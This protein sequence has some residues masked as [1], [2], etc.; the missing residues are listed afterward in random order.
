M[1]TSDIS[2]VLVIGA[3]ASGAALSWRLG[4]AG[5]KVTC[6]EQGD[7]FPLDSYPMLQADWELRRLTDF[8]A[9]PNVRRRP[10]D[11]P[12][13]NSESPFAPLMFNGVGGST[14]HW[15]AHFPRF[16]PSDFRV[17][18]LDGVADDW[19]LTYEELEPYYDL[20]DR[21]IGVSGL[22]G[23]TAYPE[24]S[25]R[26]TPPLPIGSF[27]TTLARGFDR[28]GWHWWAADT[29]IISSPFGEGRLPCNNCGPCDVGC[30]RGSRSS[31]DVTYWPRAL[32]DGVHLVTNARVREITVGSDGLASGAL[33]YD[34]SGDVREAKAAVVVMAANGIGTPRL[35][36]NSTSAQFPD[37]LAN[38]NGLVGKNLMFHP[39]AAVAG[40]FD[41]PLDSFYGPIG[42]SVYSH[43]FYETD[44]RRGFLRGYQL[45][46]VRQAGPVSV[47]LGGFTGQRVPWGPDHHR[48]MAQRV[49]HIINLGIVG[50]DFPE[51]HNQVVLDPVLTDSHGIPAPRV[52][53]RL[54]ENSERMV[55][56]AVSRA[57]EA[58]EAAGAR[59]IQ[60]NRALRPSGWHLLGTARMGDD[61]AR[62]VVDR[63]GRAHDVRNLF[64]VDG[65]VFTT[66]AAVNPT[67][68]I[69]AL[70]LRTADYLIANRRN[71]A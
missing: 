31:A 5:F 30:S 22:R 10:E 52:R 4:R 38:R 7:W 12:V 17:R 25:E 46:A 51:E 57:R 3:G 16:H 2:D 48:Q 35:L 64:I 45:Q 58:L 59:A 9:D 21:E 68:T 20:N 54:S 42:C 32:R 71:L 41:E 8:N 13:E 50:E 37:G 62:S 47:S 69:Q 29:A 56:H 53:Y 26:Q 70:A 44:E 18:S 27:G 65:S 67:T 19:P 39:F 23:D 28:L 1:G 11:Y 34:A 60:V 61:P 40:I 43:E 66:S 49:G 36:L 33:Y 14:I 63:W 55:D 24:K 15:S 6:L